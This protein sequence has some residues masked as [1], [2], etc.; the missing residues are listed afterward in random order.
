MGESSSRTVGRTVRLCLVD[1]TSHGIVIAEIGNWNGKILAAP[2]GR[3]KDLLRRPEA[4]RTG[5]YV[6]SG[7]DPDRVDGILC[8]I[9]EADDIAKRMANHLRSDAKDFA[10]RFA[11]VVSADEALTKAH[12]RYLEGRLIRLV[13]EAGTATLTNETAPDFQRLPES[14]KADMDTF[15]EHLQLTLPLLGFDLFRGTRTKDG[16]AAASGKARVPWHTARAGDLGL[17]TRWRQ[18]AVSPNQQSLQRLNWARGMRGP[19]LC[20]G[21]RVQL[22]AVSRPIAQ[23]FGAGLS[24][25]WLR[26]ATLSLALP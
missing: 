6:L 18:L 23:G 14:D 3:L 24:P 5:V 10:D 20:R 2:R 16:S 13:T 25:L 22:T 11:F 19:V 17:K 21:L 12:V 4:S 26:A 8:Y 1:G 7:P 15:L 9:G